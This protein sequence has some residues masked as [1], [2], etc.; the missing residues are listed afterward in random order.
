MAKSAWLLVLV[1]ALA[2]C[3]VLVPDE[4]VLPAPG[5]PTRAEVTALLDRVRVIDARPRPGGYERGCKVGQACVFGTAWSDDTDAPG[6]HD[7]CDTRNNVL[8]AQLRAVILRGRC[9]VVEGVLTDPYTGGDIAF[10]KSDGGRVQIDHV[11]PLAAAWDMGA[12]TWPP[13]RRLRF[14]NDLSVNLLAT[15]AS[16]NQSKG[17]DTPA[18]WL[19]PA[20]ANHCFYAAK[21]LTVAL[22]YDLP[23]TAA[24]NATLHTIA[25]GCP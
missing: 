14:A 17:D 12:A 9:V 16:T 8:A 11:Y 23:I 2:G 7:G 20:R 6:G 22:D 18:D 3:G 13:A 4:P 15:G 25:R 24:D 19:P 10:R 5:S 21:Y 1:L